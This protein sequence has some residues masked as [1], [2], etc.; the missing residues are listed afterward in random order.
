MGDKEILIIP[1]HV[2]IFMFH[3]FYVLDEIM[4]SENLG[5]YLVFVVICISSMK[6]R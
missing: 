3:I 2:G 4:R 1:R 6:Q 5:I